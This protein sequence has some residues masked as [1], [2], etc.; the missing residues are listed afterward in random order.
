MFADDYCT[1]LY[2]AKLPKYLCALAIKSLA[3]LDIWW[4]RLRPPVAFDPSIFSNVAHEFGVRRSSDCGT[5]LKAP[6]CPCISKRQ[7][8]TSSCKFSRCIKFRVN[9]AAG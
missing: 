9:A 6:T 2:A 4:D 1:R 5:A 7:I 8:I 3:K